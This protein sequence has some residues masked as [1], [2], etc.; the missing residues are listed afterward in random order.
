MKTATACLLL[1]LSFAVPVFADVLKI[2]E[3]KPVA[4]IT[5][6]EG[7]KTSVSDDMITASADD[8]SVLVNVITTRP[9]MLGPSNDKAF[10]C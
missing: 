10:G 6:P 3:D 5:F 2:P 8:D 1:A 7:W 4:A 9:D